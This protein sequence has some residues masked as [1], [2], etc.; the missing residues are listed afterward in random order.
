M[1]ESQTR[2][3]ILKDG[4]GNCYRLSHET[5]E[6]GRVPEEHKAEIERL[7]AAGTAGGDAVQGYATSLAAQDDVNGHAIMI[8]GIWFAPPA[9]E[10]NPAVPPTRKPIDGPT[11]DP[12]RLPRQPKIS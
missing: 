11:F 3:L 4:T 1:M 10:G 6:Q 2:T 8:G 5:L 7:M 12:P 9:E